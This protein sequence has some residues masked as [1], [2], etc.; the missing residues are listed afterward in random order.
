MANTRT[1]SPS[2]TYKGYLVQRDE[3]RW[4]ITPTQ[5]RFRTRRA[6]CRYIDR[7]PIGD[8]AIENTQV[9]EAGDD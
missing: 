2:I 4:F 1:F 3:F 6:A 8:L 9:E 5:Y 7:N